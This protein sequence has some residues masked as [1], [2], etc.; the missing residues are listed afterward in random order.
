MKTA[1]HLNLGRLDAGRISHAIGA[2]RWVKGS[3][4]YPV[5]KNQS[6][7]IEVAKKRTS[8]TM[9]YA[10]VAEPYIVAVR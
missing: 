8:P 10:E 7:N 3:T 2:Q 6:T 5:Q 1:P 9:V 4:G